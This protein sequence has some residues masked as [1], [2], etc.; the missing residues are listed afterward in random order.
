VIILVLL[1]LL[2]A[3]AIAF[4][5]ALGAGPFVIVPAVV[6]FAVGIWFLVGL[7]GGHTPGRDVRRVEKA[8]LLGPG[9]PD[10]PDA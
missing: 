3:L 8:K 4:T 9:G 7:V 1:F 6:A 5:L 2:V 10:D